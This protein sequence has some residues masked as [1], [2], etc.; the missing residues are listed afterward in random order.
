MGVTWK[1]GVNFSEK[2]ILTMFKE[3]KITLTCCVQCVCFAYA[4][5]RSTM[6]D[7]S[8]TP[9]SSRVEIASLNHSLMSVTTW[10]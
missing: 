5:A 10:R 9:S 4:A 6:V 7:I 8:F 1:D 3:N 2:K